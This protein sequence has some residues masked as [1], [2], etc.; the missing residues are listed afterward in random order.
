MRDP[1]TETGEY[2][3]ALWSPI[4]GPIYWLADIIYRIFYLSREKYM[5]FIHWNI[6]KLWIHKDPNGTKVSWVFVK[7][8]LLIYVAR[9]FKTVITS[10]VDFLMGFC[11]MR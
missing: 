2:L 5:L 8:N 1:S 7:F 11:M 3:F 4:M 9:I 6:L 10:N